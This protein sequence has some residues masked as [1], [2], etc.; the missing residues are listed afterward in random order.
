[1]RLSI[2]SYLDEQ[3][4][5]GR[6]FCLAIIKISIRNKLAKY[7]IHSGNFQS[8]ISSENKEK[9]ILQFVNQYADEAFRFYLDKNIF[10]NETGFKSAGLEYSTSYYLQKTLSVNKKKIKEIERKIKEINN[11]DFCS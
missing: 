8:I 11:D 3:S 7:Y 9:A 10:I 1:M 6:R 5:N 2:L 4:W